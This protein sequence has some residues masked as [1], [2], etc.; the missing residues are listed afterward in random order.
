MHDLKRVTYQTKLLFV[1]RYLSKL[2]T[3][4]MSSSELKVIPRGRTKRAFS[5]TPSQ[6]PETFEP[7]NVETTPILKKKVFKNKHE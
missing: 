2:H 5:P 6:N 4:K 3:Y 1:S 7:A